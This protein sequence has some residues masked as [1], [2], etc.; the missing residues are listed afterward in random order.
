MAFL[1]DTLLIMASSFAA[2]RGAISGD[3]SWNIQNA[4][5]LGIATTGRAITFCIHQVILS[6]H[7]LIIRHTLI[8]Y[9]VFRRS[10]RAGQAHSGRE[11][12]EPD[13]AG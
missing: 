13:R 4:V 10:V 7:E 1:Y 9:L 12:H 8:S 3:L 5:N 11:S 2:N 6:M